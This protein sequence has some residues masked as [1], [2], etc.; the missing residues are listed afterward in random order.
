MMIKQGE[1]ECVAASSATRTATS[2][3]SAEKAFQIERSSLETEMVE[4]GGC[5]LGNEG[6]EFGA[7]ISGY[8]PLDKAE[9]ASTDHSQF[10]RKPLLLLDPFNGR[11]PII[12]L[13][14][15]VATL[16]IG[17]GEEGTEQSSPP[18]GRTNQDR[19]MQWA[20]TERVVVSEQNRAIRHGHLNVACDHDV[21]GFGWWQVQQP[22]D[23]ATGETH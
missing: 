22:T 2:W 10:A 19:W 16:G 8:G 20:T 4:I 7:S 18:I 1:D 13:Q 11:Q 15:L 6:F 17:N 23:E 21:V 12:V 9:V 14:N 3:R 5:D